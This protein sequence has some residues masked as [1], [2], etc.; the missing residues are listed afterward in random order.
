MGI[1]KEMNCQRVKRKKKNQKT[2]WQT[3]IREKKN[4]NGLRGEGKDLGK[5]KRFLVLKGQDLTR[6]EDS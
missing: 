5:T 3:I 1:C 2:H 6:S 4:K